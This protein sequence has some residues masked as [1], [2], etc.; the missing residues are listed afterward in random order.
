MR[1][2]IVDDDASMRALLSSLLASRGYQVV[3][4]LAD[5]TR[6]METICRESPD[7]VCLDY[8]LPGRDGLDILREISEVAPQI[9]TLFMTASEDDALEKM[10]ANAGAAG[11]IRKP[12]GQAQILKEV[13]LVWSTRQQANA[14]NEKARLDQLL[15]APDRVPE[16]AAPTPPRSPFNP[17]SVVI[18]DDN[19]TIRLLLKGLLGS[20][21]F[22]VVQLVGN[23]E[24]A[25]T[26]AR[27]HQPGI[28]CLDVEMP[29]MSGID[30]LP[31]IRQASPRTAVVMVTA[32]ATR[33]L[34]EKAAAHGAKGYIVKPLRPAYVEEFMKQLFR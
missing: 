16:A 11:F 3:A 14:A 26:A 27:T 1:V 17:R 28:L 12:F 20:L 33:E 18:A 19:A 8:H 9:D 13:E 25:V 15:V 4:A 6:L 31:L 22:D 29:Q 30:A 32:S 23:G 7:I 34:V 2:M 10:A 5:G 21:D 24:E